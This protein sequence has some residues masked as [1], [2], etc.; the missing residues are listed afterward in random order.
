MPLFID[1][2]CHLDLL[3][4]SPYQN[5]FST[6]I[7]AEKHHKIDKMLCISLDLATYPAMYA[8]VKDYPEIYLSLG[9]QPNVKP[10][11]P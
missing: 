8:L 7:R 10:E 5:D 11:T 4:L 1:S 6:F 2:H 9:V 3:D